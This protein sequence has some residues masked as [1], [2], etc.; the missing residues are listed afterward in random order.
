MEQDKA[1]NDIIVEES[2]NSST[3][4]TTPVIEPA[5]ANDS[6][7][8]ALK[9]TRS[10]R[11]TM[12]ILDISPSLMGVHRKESE[13]EPAVKEPW[14]AKRVFKVTWNYVT[15]VKVTTPLRSFRGTPL[16]LGNRGF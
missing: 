9:A 16:M 12:N 4:T 14:T 13:I 2:D 8:L 6:D 10:R 5:P 15:T 3:S 11:P 1:K 7:G